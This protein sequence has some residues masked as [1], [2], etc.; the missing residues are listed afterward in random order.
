VTGQRVSWDLRREDCAV[1]DVR[2]WYDQD[3]ALRVVVRLDCT[4]PP[5]PTAPSG[6]SGPHISGTIWSDSCLLDRSRG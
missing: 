4:L 2:H 1:F 3:G 6:T 5:Q